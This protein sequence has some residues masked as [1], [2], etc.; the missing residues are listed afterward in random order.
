MPSDKRR[1][2]L[3]LNPSTLELADELF[4]GDNCKSRS[5]FIE[6]AIIFYAGYINS[7]KNMKYLPEILTS[8]LK[9]IV[10]EGLKKQNRLL[11]KIAVELSVLANV[12]AATNEISP[13]ELQR[14]RGECVKEVNK[15]NGTMSFEDAIVWQE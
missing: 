7:E 14:L 2:Q 8:T 5:E 15:I 11:Y 12:I 13:I 3:W 6:K 4:E 1:F 10:T 9:G